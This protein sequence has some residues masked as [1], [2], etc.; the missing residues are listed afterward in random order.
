MR[1]TLAGWSLVCLLVTGC[2]TGGQGSVS[3]TATPGTVPADRTATDP[4]AQRVICQW[5]TEQTPDGRT[6]QVPTYF[7]VDDQGRV[8]RRLKAGEVE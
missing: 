7:L 4:A 5:H 2:G 3:T 1:A 6:I 8:V